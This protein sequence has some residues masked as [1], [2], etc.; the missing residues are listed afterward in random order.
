LELLVHTHILHVV[1]QGVIIRMR[2]HFEDF[3]WGGLVDSE[4]EKP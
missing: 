1:E 4:N 3:D 2:T